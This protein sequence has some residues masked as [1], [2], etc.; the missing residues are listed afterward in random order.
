MR[1][2]SPSSEQEALGWLFARQCFGVKLGLERMRALLTRLGEPQRRFETVLVGGTN[3][4]GSVSSTLA[5]ILT[6]TGARTGLFTSPHLSHFSERF[7]VSGEPVQD[8]LLWDALGEVRPH[9]EAL[10]ATFFEIVTVLGCL[11][12]ARSGVEVAVIEVGMGGR[13]DATNVLSPRLTVITGVA[14][15]HTEVLGETL[16]AIAY[17]KAGIMRAGVP[18]FTGA[19]G[20]ALTVL[21]RE[22]ARL[23]TPLW[24]LGRELEVQVSER[25]WAGSSLRLLSSVGDLSVRDL[26]VRDL[27]VQTPLLGAHGARNAAL[28]VAA[29]QAL[30]VEEE[31]IQRGTAATRWP[32]RLEPVG[33]QGQTFLLD[34]AHNPEAAAALAGALQLLRVAPARLIF[35]ASEDKALEEMVRSLA[36]ATREVIVTR[37]QRSPRS[38]LPDALAELWRAA[39]VPVRVTT[40]P[41][42]AV[43]LAL[44]SSRPDKG[45]SDDLWVVAGSL[46]LIGEVRPM[47]L[48]EVAESWAR[49]Q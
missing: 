26:P 3:G 10:G 41:E 25:G 19:T 49:F 33:Y 30:G 37:A 14:L 7:V 36:P 17:E 18:C 23:E 29:A 11:L 48:G 46:Y 12:F 40:S 6:Q 16:G 38:S 1:G 39:S 31:A 22:A 45:A 35:G 13:F 5:G 24:V 20:E 42:E 2:S 9:A 8:P 15:D 32:G 34:G 44:G 21:E 43:Q 27:A 47:L 4:K 28:A